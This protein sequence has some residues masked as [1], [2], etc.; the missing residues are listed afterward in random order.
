MNKV[1]F[2]M[3]VS[4]LVFGTINLAQAND[5]KK[6]KQLKKV[7]VYE[8]FEDMKENKVSTVELQMIERTNKKGEKRY[9]LP[10]RKE[11]TLCYAIGNGEDIYYKLADNDFVKLKDLGDNFYCFDKPE[12]LWVNSN[13]AVSS[14]PTPWLNTALFPVYYTDPYF[15]NKETGVVAEMTKRNVRAALKANESLLKEFEAEK[16]KGVKKRKK[17]LSKL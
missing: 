17:Y 3:I 14:I 12:V 9:K 15:I 6:K 10:K 16:R 2:G 1:I 13:G 11:V 7:E 4:V 5:K 8:S